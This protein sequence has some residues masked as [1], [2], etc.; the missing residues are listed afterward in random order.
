VARQFPVSPTTVQR[1]VESACGQR[2]DRADLRDRL[3]APHR[4]ANRVRPDLEDL[5]LQ[6]RRELRNHSDLG[7][8]G[9]AAIRRELLQRGLT[10]P[11]SLRTIGRIL[12]RRGV[13]DSRHRVRRQ[14]PPVGWYLPEVAARRAELD[15]FDV[16]AGLIIKGGPEVVVLNGISLHGGVIASWPR[17]AMTAALTRAALVEQRRAVGLPA[18]APFDHDT[19][20]QGPHPYPDTIGTVIRLCLSLGVAPVFAVPHEMGIQAAIARLN[21][22]WH[23]RV[24]ARFQHQSLEALQ[25]QSAT[26]VLASRQRAAARIEASPPRRPFPA[27][28]RLNL[29]AALRGRMIYLR[30]TSEQG[31]VTLLGHTFEVDPLW[32][33]RLVRCE[34]DIDAAV[35]RFYALRRREPDWQPLLREVAYRLSQRYY[36]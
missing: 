2:L 10:A 5:V 22:R 23:A 20:V 25:A 27:Q 31:S 9:A 21:G 36:P 18:S 30:R 34:V 7:E 15:E 11:P 12:E 35:I 4:V 28:W 32:S 24:R 13:L 29:T 19:R 17:T 3:S 14:A 16:V 26:Y 1:W 6:I 8:F 33:H